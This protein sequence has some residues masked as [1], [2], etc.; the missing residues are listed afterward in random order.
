ML[1]GSAFFLI[2]RVGAV[3]GS[4]AIR[5]SSG[6]QKKKKKEKLASTAM[7]R[8]LSQKYGNDWYNNP[9]ITN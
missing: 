7:N 2:S 9:H 5:L 4:G 6:V 8:Q 1:F 3:A